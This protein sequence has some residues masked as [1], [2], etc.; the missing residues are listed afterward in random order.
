M[1]SLSRQMQME[2]YFRTRKIEGE[3]FDCKTLLANV[4]KGCE[5]IAKDEQFT[6]LDEAVAFLRNYAV[7]RDIAA[8]SHYANYLVKY[9][10]TAEQLKTCHELVEGMEEVKLESHLKSTFFHE[11]RVA[12]F[13]ARELEKIL[14]HFVVAQNPTD[15]HNL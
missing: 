4:Q 15:Q 8:A 12:P 11:V 13:G 10:I 5:K 6:D 1:T 9:G 14:R 2:L 7:V 3:D